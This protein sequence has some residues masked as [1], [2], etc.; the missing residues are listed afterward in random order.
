MVG[1]F[2]P[3]CSSSSF[4]A[5]STSSSFFSNTSSSGFSSSGSV[6]ISWFSSEVISSVPKLIFSSSSIV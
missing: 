4:S 6:D 5:D 3:S 2:F 1:A